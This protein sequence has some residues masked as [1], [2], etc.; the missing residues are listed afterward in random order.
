LE[1][2]GSITC[3][4]A[5]CVFIRSRNGCGG[6]HSIECVSGLRQI[7]LPFSNAMGGS[8]RHSSIIDV[9]ED[10]AAY[11]WLGGHG[12]RRHLAHRTDTQLQN[13][14]GNQPPLV[15][16]SALANSLLEPLRMEEKCLAVSSAMCVRVGG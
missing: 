10:D 1:T 8:M 9:G 12:P 6:M 11:F 15:L 4:G 7:R 5:P 2:G 13:P 14:H 16:F 3:H